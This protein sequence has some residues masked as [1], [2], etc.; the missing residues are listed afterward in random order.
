MA[1][2]FKIGKIVA[3]FGVNGELILKHHLGKKI[4]LKGLAVFFVEETEGNFF[5]YFIRSS[6]L[7]NEDEVMLK[8]E[9]IEKK[10]DAAQLK[11]K[12]CWLLE[13]D[14]IK[15][16]A[17]S[18]P[19]SLLGYHLINGEEDL[20]KIIEVIEQP[21]QVLCTILLNKKEAFIPIHEGSLK[22]IDRKKQQVF[23]DLPDGLLEIYK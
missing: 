20:G 6:S 1:E 13:A 9:G 5:P 3:A 11:S 23:V 18:A 7:R 21:H 15:F 12:D 4:S 8:V 16:S 19:I 22:K 17:K 10:E 14:F 2:Y